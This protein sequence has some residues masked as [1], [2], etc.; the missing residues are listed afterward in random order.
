MKYFT[1][2]LLVVLLCAFG[3]SDTRKQKLS[4][5]FVHSQTPTKGVSKKQTRLDITF[6]TTTGQVV[7][8]SIRYSHNGIN[9]VLYPNDKGFAQVLVPAGKT[10][11]QFL[12]TTNYFE[13]YSDTV[14]LLGGNAAAVSV[15]FQDA[16]TEIIS[17]KPVIYVYPTAAQQVNIRLDVRGTLG[18]T[19]PAYYF[20]LNSDSAQSGW[21]FTAH[22]DGTIHQNGE[23]YDYL[24]WDAKHK[25][26]LNSLDT[27]TGFIVQRDSL[28]PF[29]EKQ[30]GAMN[31]SPREQQDF[32]TYWCPRMLMNEKSFVQFAFNENYDQFAGITITPKP[33]HVFRV[34]MLWK[35]AAGMNAHKV[36]PQ[37]IESVTR[38]GFT[39]LEWGGTELPVG[40]TEP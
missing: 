24:F 9:G 21:T 39:V 20:P 15:T 8:D 40:N 25:F 19:Y 27:K 1:F 7:T 37:K 16:Y 22:P 38:E 26:S 34:M 6:T 23:E 10:R 5:C 11:F 4:G 13:V 35:N 33:D 18:F 17:D 29:F 28:V 3:E 32:I 2:L 12:Y 30:L 31:L 36:Q 14:T